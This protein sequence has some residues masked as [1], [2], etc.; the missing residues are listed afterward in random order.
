M[1]T[2]IVKQTN[3][4]YVMKSPGWENLGEAVSSLLPYVYTVADVS[5]MQ[6]CRTTPKVVL[7]EICVEQ[8]TQ[9]FSCYEEGCD[10]SPYLWWE[11]QNIWSMPYHIV[12]RQHARVDCNREYE[13]RESQSPALDQYQHQRESAGHGGTNLEMGGA[14]QNISIADMI[15]FE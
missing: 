15:A 11:L 8:D 13:G 4:R 6:T 14:A 5:H 3:R 7:T 9:V 10:K 2:K 1:P 12:S